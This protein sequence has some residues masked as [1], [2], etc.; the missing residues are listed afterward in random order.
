MSEGTA[1]A[2]SYSR[3]SSF[4]RL[5]TLP[6]NN[7]D[8][9]DNASNGNAA[10]ANDGT[11]LLHGEYGGGN[12]LSLLLRQS[13]QPTRISS[14]LGSSYD[15]DHFVDRGMHWNTCLA[16]VLLMEE[17][18]EEEEEDKNGEIRAMSFNRDGILLATGDNRRVVRI[19]DFDDVRFMDVKRRNKI[20]WSQSLWHKIESQ[21]RGKRRVERRMSGDVVNGCA[22]VDASS[23]VKDTSIDLTLD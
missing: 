18:E 19:Y 21:G 1:S 22:E 23:A 14:S 13:C 7:D 17:E 4:P 11:H 9:N 2:A 12:I 6:S 15:F 5:I 8:D 10:A 3:S 20:S 16:V